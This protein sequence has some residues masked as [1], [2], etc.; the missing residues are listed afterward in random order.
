M[1]NL[2]DTPSNGW[3]ILAASLVSAVVVLSTGL[4]TAA[5][6]S[7]EDR[8]NAEIVHV[9]LDSIIH[10]VA[11]EFLAEAI[12]EAES[13]RAQAL[14]IELNTPGGVLASTRIIGSGFLE[15]EIPVVIFVSPQ[16]SRAAS[17]GFFLLMAA[18]VAVMAPGTNT[19]AAHPI[20]GGG[21][22]IPGVLGEKVEEDAA[23]WIRSL[24]TQHG[25]NEEAAESAVVES[26]SFSADEALEEGLIDFIAQ[27]MDDLLEQ[28]DGFELVKLGSPITLH[29][30]EAT[31]ET[32]EMS[33]FQ[34]LRSTVAN[35]DL[36]MAL[37]SIGATALIIELWS[38]GAIL[39]GVVGAICLILGGYGLSILPL[40]WAGVA[41]LLLAVL[42][43]ALEIKV[44]SYGVLTAGG[45][46]SLVLGSLFLFRSP[47]PAIRISLQMIVAIAL[48]AVVTVTLLMTTVIRARG[49]Q[50][51][52]GQEGL[53]HEK[54]VARTVIDPRG[55]V[56]VH[57]EIWN[58]VADSSVA[59]GQEIE[60]E[61]VEG[62]TLR[63][64]PT[65]ES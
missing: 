20:A 13:R 55:K 32:L 27:D 43:L 8:P 38:P 50:V 19:G 49:S 21:Q 7:G 34:K 39:P 3:R 60:V 48:V 2:A 52:T 57:G 35:P 59:A 45:V 11:A 22:D 5:Q 9:R 63:I 58:A 53:V 42:L 4:V 10:S 28:L 30:L 62:M 23:A 64:R 37:A 16:G 36:A 17:A 41:L 6:D 29:S 46:T 12:A 15:S 14:V 65:Q 33:P 44:P 54:G 56:S 31:L 47:D 24:A 26:H 40:S 51:S 18:D 1:T 25:R 61:A